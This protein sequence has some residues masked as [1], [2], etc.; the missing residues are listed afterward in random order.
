M[1][2]K[3]IFI[4]DKKKYLKDIYGTNDINHPGVNFFL[5]K[6]NFFVNGEIKL[7]KQIKKK[8]SISKLK[9][10]L[11]NF[12]KITGYHTRNIPHKAHEWIINFGL[13]KTSAILINP[14]TGNLK[15]GDFKRSIVNKSFKILI[16]SK[17]KNN[18]NIFYSDLLTYA[19]YAGPREALFH[20]IIRKNLGCTHFLVG[21]DHAGVGSYYK[22]YAS[23]KVCK[24]YEK[25]IQIKIISFKEPFYCKYCKNVI[26]YKCNH[27]NL[28]N[29]KTLLS[30]TK[31]RERILNNQKIPEFILDK[32]ISKILTKKSIRGFNS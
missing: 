15:R 12:E 5:K 25:K 21:R 6:K 29:Y 13:K 24:K 30:G 1:E 26:N 3:K 20:A 4:I 19:R 22:K 2:K 10:K 9:N 18:K 31:I 11:N 17:Y 16:N 32:R 28:K 14:M 7:N 27:S 8:Y 23:Q